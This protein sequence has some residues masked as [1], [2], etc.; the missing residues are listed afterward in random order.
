MA[1]KNTKKTIDNTTNEEIEIV[2]VNTNVNVDDIMENIS[3]NIPEEINVIT[4]ELENVKPSDDFVETIITKPE[5]AQEMLNVK[6]EE[7]SNIETMVQ[8]EIQKIMDNNPSIKKNKNFTYMW[9]G[10]NL[11]E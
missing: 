1:K 3:K 5:Q 7:L 6:L 4:T 10:V 9:N 11:Y 2:S 8:K